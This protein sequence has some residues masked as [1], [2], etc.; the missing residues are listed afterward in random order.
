[1]HG[2]ADKNDEINDEA[3]GDRMTEWLY[4][5]RGGKS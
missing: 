1:M 5:A 3:S 4:L 2:G